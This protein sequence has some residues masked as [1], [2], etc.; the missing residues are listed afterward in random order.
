MDLNIK[1]KKRKITN[2]KRF[3]YSFDTVHQ[4][5]IGNIIK[6]YNSSCRRRTTCCK[7]FKNLKS[8][9][10]NNQYTIVIIRHLGRFL[11]FFLFKISTYIGKL[12]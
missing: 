5:S 11:V 3:M 9:C 7:K 10:F 8:E 4:H 2:F 1:S 12:I 6:Q